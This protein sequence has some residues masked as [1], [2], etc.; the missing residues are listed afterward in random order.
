V[1]TL[2]DDGNIVIPSICDSNDNDV[3][4]DEGCNETT[5]LSNSGRSHHRK[6]TGARAFDATLE[7]YRARQ[8][9]P[10]SVDFPNMQPSFIPYW[11]ESNKSL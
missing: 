9:P 11:T 5:T 1:K 10:P 6:T 3:S 4:Y 8:I 2:E 7:A